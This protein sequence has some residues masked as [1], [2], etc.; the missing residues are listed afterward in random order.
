[1]PWL[2]FGTMHPSRRASSIVK[3]PRFADKIAIDLLVPSFLAKSLVLAIEK[4]LAANKK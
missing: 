4:A 2:E 1:V 3:S